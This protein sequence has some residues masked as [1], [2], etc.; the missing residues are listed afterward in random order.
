MASMKMA[1]FWIVAP[2]VWYKFTD[3]TNVLAASFIRGIIIK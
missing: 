3:V 2:V 1:A